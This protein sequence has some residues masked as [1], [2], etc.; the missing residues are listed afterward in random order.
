MIIKIDDWVFDVDIAATMAYSAAE[1]A[2]H[3][4]CGFCR[5][6]YAALDC[7]YGEVRPFLAQFG[8][9]AESPDAMSPVPYSD[10]HLGYDPEYIVI[11]KLLQKG[12]FEIPCGNAS[13]LAETPGKDTYPYD[14][15]PKGTECFMLYVLDLTLPWVLDEPL[16]TV[17]SPANDPSLVSRLLD[18][19]LG[20]K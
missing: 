5:N 2:A 12:N 9:D 16:D 7:H 20:R 15:L 17:Q 11:G 10:S 6:F 13:I 19:L 3:C 18:K 8:I 1:A 4:D 14:R